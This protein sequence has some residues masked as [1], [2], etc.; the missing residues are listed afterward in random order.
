MNP[1]VDDRSSA[2]TTEFNPSEENFQILPGKPQVKTIIKT[3]IRLPITPISTEVIKFFEAF[4][5]IK[6]SEKKLQFIEA[7]KHRLVRSVQGN[8]LF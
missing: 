8:S 3:Q 4:D 7:Q 2:A 1:E 6:S 5:R